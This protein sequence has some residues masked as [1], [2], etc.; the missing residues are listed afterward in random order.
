[1]IGDSQP[2]YGRL[3]Q[4]KIWKYNYRWQCS[5]RKRKAIVSS[6]MDALSSWKYENIIIDGSAVYMDALSSWKY[7]NIIVDGSAVY[8]DALSSWKYEYRWQCSRISA[9][10]RHLFCLKQC[11]MVAT[12]VTCAPLLGQN[13]ILYLYLE[14]TGIALY[15]S[16]IVPVYHCTARWF[17]Y[18][19]P[20]FRERKL[21]LLAFYQ[22]HALIKIFNSKIYF[23]DK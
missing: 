9:E 10:K 3:V 1:M 2:H 13:G 17:W 7:E 16:T 23:S 15:H 5:R 8:M 21:I 6:T 14:H 20:M 12:V 4:L 22:T 18:F 19:S 11:K